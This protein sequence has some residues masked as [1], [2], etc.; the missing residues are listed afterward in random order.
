MERR[1]LVTLAEAV[2]LGALYS[3]I[4]RFSAQD[5]GESGSLSGM[6]SEKCVEF[7]NWLSGS[8]WNAAREAELAEWLE[9]PL[10]KLA[11]FSEYACMGVLVYTLWSQWMV[12]RKQ[13]CI[14]T[15]IWVFLSASGDEIHQYFVPGRCARF[16]DVLIDTGGG[17]FGMLFC[18]AVCAL[19][20]KRKEK[21]KA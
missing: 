6:I 5:G 10:R 14:L 2:L 1:V 13:L 4:F 17:V 12:R 19:Y 20:R 16:T 18:L 3:L 7:A 8:G 15:V 9:Y 21:K 11:H